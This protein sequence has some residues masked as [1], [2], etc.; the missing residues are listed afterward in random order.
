MVNTIPPSLPPLDFPCK[1]YAREH[2]SGSWTKVKGLIFDTTK[3]AIHKIIKI[4]W[5]SET[6]MRLN[7]SLEDENCY[8]KFALGETLEEEKSCLSFNLEPNKKKIVYLYIAED[9][10]KARVKKR[11]LRVGDF[12]KIDNIFKVSVQTLNEVIIMKGAALLKF[13]T[14]KWVNQHNNISLLVPKN[15]RHEKLNNPYYV[16]PQKKME[17]QSI[18]KVNTQLK[19]PA[20]ISESTRKVTEV[21]GEVNPDP[22]EFGENLDC[23]YKAKEHSNDLWKK[24][25]GLLFRRI[26]NAINKQLL[27]QWSSD[28]KQQVTL[29]VK[30]QEGYPKFAL[31]APFVENKEEIIISPDTG[32][33][34]V[35]FDLEPGRKL[36]VLL[37]IAHGPHQGK[38]KRGIFKDFQSIQNVFKVSIKTRNREILEKTADLRFVHPS[39]LVRNQEKAIGEDSYGLLNNPYLLQPREQCRKRP[40]ENSS[41]N[42]QP[43]KIK[44]KTP[45]IPIYPISSTEISA[46]PTPKE[47]F[48]DPDNET[49]I[50]AFTENK[51]II[52]YP[53]LMDI[54]NVS[55]KFSHI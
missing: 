23:E 51:E 25:R 34:T 16:D 6:A 3:N 17:K 35:T 37:F 10:E 47:I 8:P 46:F 9:P 12:K 2:G 27:T 26:P 42:P 55:V 15:S 45:E 29:S 48:S 21:N 14:H 7:L 24:A 13:V 28:E 54:I 38:K 33:S 32:R 53:E 11:Q 43:I 44:P 40:L 5:K 4:R 30:D 31:T 52:I 1:Y 36:A 19:T 20:L 50:Y 39:W 22:H 18:L 41:P 49:P